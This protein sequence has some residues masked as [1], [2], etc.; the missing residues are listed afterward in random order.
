MVTDPEGLDC[1][2]AIDYW[3]G[4]GAGQAGSGGKGKAIACACK[5]A[6]LIC[7]RMVRGRGFRGICAC[8]LIPEGCRRWLECMG[9]CIKD[10]YPSLVSVYTATNV[11]FQVHPPNGERKSLK[12]WCANENSPDCCYAHSVLE[13]MAL[14]HC[15]DTGASAGGCAHLRHAQTTRNTCHH[16]SGLPVDCASVLANLTSMSN[17]LPEWAGFGDPEF[18]YDGNL[19]QMINASNKACCDSDWPTK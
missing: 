13:K 9:N 15:R 17:A 12:E 19:T 7:N 14:K 8:A 6:T 1:Q 5:V 11:E 4:G 3:C 2:P 18:P 16:P 10:T